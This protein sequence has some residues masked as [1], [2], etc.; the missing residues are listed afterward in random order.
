[1]KL[2]V[3]GATGFIGHHF[4]NNFSEKY[5]IVGLSRQTQNSDT[6]CMKKTDYSKESLTEILSDCS[7]IL[8][9]AAKRPYTD[10]SD[11]FS[12]NVKMDVNIFSTALDLGIENIVF[13]SS[14]SVYGNRRGPWSENQSLQPET[15]YALAK[16]QSELSA[17]YFNRKGLCIKSL[18]IAQ[19]F[20]IGEYENSAISTFIRNCDNNQPIMITVKGIYREYIYIRDLTNAF[21]AA[22]SKPSAK[23][24]FNVGSGEILSLEQI[25]G[26]IAHAFGRRSLVQ[27][28]DKPKQMNEYSIMDSS[29]F[30]ETFNWSPEYTFKKAANEVVK[31]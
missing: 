22:L 26:T 21:D 6:V 28:A 27:T 15:L 8:H 14:R 30:Y 11:D 17:E 3:T 31:N 5:E 10:E 12:G 16:A 18:R 23:G 2:A 1:M 4:I 29:L 24:V 25:A 13:C 7:A 20:G 19:V 9:L